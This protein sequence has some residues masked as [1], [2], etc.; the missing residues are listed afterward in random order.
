M[1]S[2]TRHAKTCRV[3]YM[4]FTICRKRLCFSLCFVF[5]LHLPLI[6]QW[7]SLGLL[8]QV[9][10]NICT[11]SN[12]ICV[13]VLISYDIALILLG[14]PGLHTD[15]LSQGSNG[16]N[17]IWLWSLRRKL[18]IKRGRPLNSL[19][20]VTLIRIRM[21]SV[22]SGMDGGDRPIQCMAGGGSYCCCCDLKR[23]HGDYCHAKFG[24]VH[25]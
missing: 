13:Y 8:R 3:L 18:W 16:L 5:L 7:S 20:W 23:G 2:R 17:D 9:A 25:F 22:H 21:W 14:Y 10:I 1:P 12:I 24:K 6:S 19:T 15:R 11:R 4:Q